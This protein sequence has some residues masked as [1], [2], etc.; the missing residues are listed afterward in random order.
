[1]RAAV[2]LLVFLSAASAFAQDNSS[3]A[4]KSA[5]NERR[6]TISTLD[7]QR[8]P[9][10]SPLPAILDDNKKPTSFPLALQEATDLR[11]QPSDQPSYLRWKATKTGSIYGRLEFLGGAGSIRLSRDIAQN[12]N[13]GSNFSAGCS[14]DG[15][16]PANIYRVMAIRW[17][18]IQNAP[19]GAVSLEVND[20]WFD[21]RDCKAY[22]E[23]RT[24]F[25]LKAVLSHDE[26][27]VLFGSRTDD[28][29]LLHFPPSARVVTDS[30]GVSSPSF[31]GALWSV[32]VPLRKGQATSVLAEM[33]PRDVAQWLASFQTAPAPSKAPTTPRQLQ[34]GVEVLQTVKDEAPTIL[35]RSTI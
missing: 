10:A 20:G 18:R 29:I 2:A 34:L 33:N 22:V 7:L 30:S 8:L 27:P 28:G 13:R 16:A 11:F 15:G 1:M 23:R 12:Y 4:R 25:P 17:E 31:Q 3:R 35:L 14:N 26:T 9:A 21:G 32:A 19:G 5:R 24:V 6:T